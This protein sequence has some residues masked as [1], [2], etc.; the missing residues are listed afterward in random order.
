MKKNNLINSLVTLLVFLCLCFNAVALDYNIS[1]TG[2]GATTS[3]GNV[4]VQNLTRGNVVVVPAGNIL[5][6]TDQTNA[7]DKLSATDGDL[8]IYPSGEQGKFIVTFFAATTGNTVVNAYSI[9]GRKMSEIKVNLQTGQS[10]FELSIP[11]GLFV[12]KVSGNGYMY[13]GKL[14][15]QS[16]LFNDK[17]GIVFQNTNTNDISG[18][19]KVATGSSV[20]KLTYLA[21]DLILLKANSGNYST[22]LTDIPTESK[23]INFA[24]VECKDASGNYYPIVKIGSQTWMADNLK[25][26]KYRT[27][28]DIVNFTNSSD[29]SMFP[30]GALCN[31]D[32]NEALGGVYGKLYNWYAVSDSRNI[33]PQGWHIPSDAEW[34]S[35]TTQLGGM[36]VAGAKLK[37]TGVL[38]WNNPNTGAINESG[39]TAIPAGN[40]G[41]GNGTF[42]E[43]GTGAFWWTSTPQTD[44]YGYFRSI[45][46][47]SSGVG[48][49]GS[50]KV[51]GLSVRCIKDG[52][53]PTITTAVPGTIA[54]TTAISGGNI[55]SD[56][57]A[58]VSARGV[59]W[60]KTNNPTIADNK[61]ID[62]DG[63]GLFTSVVTGLDINS[64]YY[65]RAY[66]TNNAGTAYGE[67]II[68]N[69]LPYDSEVV[70]DVDGNIYHSITIGT[71][72][73]MVENLKTTKY[74]NGDVIGTTSY[75][76]SSLTSAVE[77][78][79]QWAYEGNEADVSIYGRLYTWHTVADNRNIA[80]AGW[81]VAT[82]AEWATLQNYLI[83]NGYNHDKT[84]VG[85][86]I[87]KSMCTTKL[88]NTSDV[89]GTAS[90]EMYK[91]N[92]SGFSMVPNG[93]RGYDGYFYIKGIGSNT[94]TSTTES[95]TTAIMR[96]C[97]YNV[98]DLGRNTSNKNY[99]FAVRCMKNSIPE[100]STSTTT[101]ILSTSIKC[102]GIV[103]ADGGEAVT[104]YGVCW[105]KIELPTL[106]DSTK[107][108]GNGIAAFITELTALEPNT[109]Y[110]VRAYAINS[111]GVAY[112]AQV[113]FKTLLTDPET[114][115]DAD[116][117]VYHTVA[118]GNQTWMVENLKTTK[119]NDGTS[120]PLV[121]DSY[122]WITLSAP[123]Y[124]WA[125]N[126]IENKNY[127]GAS[128]N[129]YAVSTGKLA[130]TGWH[131][132]TESD[133]LALTA[134]LGGTSSAGAALKE[135]GLNHW[136]T[137]NI[138]ASNSSGFTALPGGYRS[139]ASGDFVNL[140]TRA[141][142][143][144]GTEL[145]GLGGR[146][147][148]ENNSTNTDF[149]YY[150]KTFGFSV[151][152]IKD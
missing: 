37:E 76:Y 43:M 35:L 34:T 137:P 105:S 135:V 8:K 94:W 90:F 70:T 59:C 115:T 124:C 123:G 14:I 60:S 61:T 1:F 33:A 4:V 11:R 104:E 109:T 118:I 81:H 112:G 106:S 40:R 13:S 111:L 126:N 74:R 107:V 80:P 66:A 62:G 148:I 16:G 53:L 57:G 24:F 48:R 28:D 30:I 45:G 51:N 83:S 134:H 67:S 38:R 56:G 79:Y 39:F 18:V 50:A 86:K 138:G 103:V 54:Y 144:G 110:Y 122:E 114:V 89:T 142:L 140:Y 26:T 21:G 121:A 52:E 42:A 136:S 102:G 108:V 100:V 130:P 55:I 19:K 145:N 125:N 101:D 23:T 12:V 29:W 20:V 99:G 128:Y 152:C 117:N 25:T 98:P 87:A 116:G 93:Y 73:W 146:Y 2:S 7:L 143:W 6:L 72:K 129:Y 65:V 150:S 44:V 32:N 97:G 113:S 119:Y 69:S 36:D 92:A 47:S 95:A 9:D 77:P 139:P 96:G 68:F 131:V 82:D 133:W 127:Y 141:V 5:N 22:I 17:S 10:S 147:I 91:N 88:W 63:T 46:Y 132:P 3:V 58:A 120:I 149:S 78:K 85:N 27:G 84:T 31:Y 71:Q 151:R 41:N 49:S 64:T 75:L 15:N